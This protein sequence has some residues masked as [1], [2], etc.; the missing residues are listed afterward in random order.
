MITLVG[1]GSDKSVNEQ[2]LR[3]LFMQQ[4]PQNIRPVLISHGDINLAKL[5]EL[6][7]MIL[8][9]APMTTISTITTRGDDWPLDDAN[10]PL[11]VLVKKMDELIWLQW[12]STSDY[13]R[14]R[15]R[16]RKNNNYKGTRSDNR[17]ITKGDQNVN[18]F[19]IM[20][21]LV[22]RLESLRA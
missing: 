11:S 6:A 21:N 15:H 13:N 19:G 20:P 5:A 2:I 4:M 14:R 7:N 3:E 12:E 17:S 22:R 8:E 10:S 9:T 16:N 18:V 1:E